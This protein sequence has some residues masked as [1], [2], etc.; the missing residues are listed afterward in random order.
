MCAYGQ[1]EIRLKCNK[2]QN[3]C[4][5]APFSL[6]TR[7]GALKQLSISRSYVLAM[8]TFLEYERPCLIHIV[9]SLCSVC[10][11]TCGVSITV[12]GWGLGIVS[13]RESPVL[14]CCSTSKPPKRSRLSQQLSVSICPIFSSS[15]RTTALLF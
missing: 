10:V 2:V 15:C 11:D 5:E 12:L 6:C 3:F 8:C 7:T 1:N 9:S 4:Y 13:V 14:S